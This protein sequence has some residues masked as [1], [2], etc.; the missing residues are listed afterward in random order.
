MFLM[1]RGARPVLA[2]E[3]RVRADKCRQNLDWKLEA[4]KKDISNG[5]FP[6]TSTLF[7]L[8][9]S[10]LQLS[11][12]QWF[13]IVFGIPPNGRLTF[14]LRR[15]TSSLLSVFFRDVI[16]GSAGRGCVSCPLV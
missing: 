4:F 1:F 16:M 6:T 8:S 14:L 2:P 9:E 3:H 15:F 11:K 10:V 7:P 12:V 13:G 5:L